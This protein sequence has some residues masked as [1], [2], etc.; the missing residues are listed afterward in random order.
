EEKARLDREESE[1]Q[2]ERDES[3]RDESESQESESQFERDESESQAEIYSKPNHPDPRVI[4]PQQLPNKTLRFQ[5]KWFRDFPWLHYSPRGLALRGHDS[6]EGNLWQLLRLR[7]G[8][9]D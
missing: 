9:D 7:S 2:F 6:D 4:P 5:E 1:S 3:E 8:D